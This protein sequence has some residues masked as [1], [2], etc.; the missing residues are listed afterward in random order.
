MIFSPFKKYTVLNER[1][2]F[3]VSIT[4]ALS[5]AATVGFYIYQEYT[6]AGVVL[7]GTVT[8]LFQYIMRMS[9]SFYNFAW[10]YSQVV[11]NRI[12]AQTVDHIVASYNELVKKHN[13][14]HF[15]NRSH[16]DIAHLS[17]SYRQDGKAKEVL[18]DISMHIHAGEKIA[19][20]GASGCGKS[21]FMM[22]LRGLYDVDHAEIT[23]DGTNVDG[24]HVLAYHTSLIPQDP[25]IFENTIRYNITVGTEVDDE[26]L[27]KALHLAAFDE[28]VEQLP[29]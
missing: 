19:F 11:Q 24:L 1:K 27:Q 25:E 14:P 4:L 18:N 17:F 10:Q 16:I 26:K 7:V 6:V 12:N 13:V 22:L 2:R 5:T 29:K 21:T 23:I 9:D 8:M 20:V 28:V 3:A 15:R